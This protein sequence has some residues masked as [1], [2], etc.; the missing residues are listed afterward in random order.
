MLHEA[1]QGR[2]TVSL[3]RGDYETL[4]ATGKLPALLALG[5]PLQCARFLEDLLS[6][7]CEDVDE[8][9]LLLAQPLRDALSPFPVVALEMLVQN[10]GQLHRSAMGAALVNLITQGRSDGERTVILRAISSVARPDVEDD[11]EEEEEAHESVLE[12]DEHASN[13]VVAA[14]SATGVAAV[15]VV[16][17][18]EQCTRCHLFKTRQHFARHQRKTRPKGAR[19]CI[20]CT[21][22]PPGAA[23]C[24]CSNCQVCCVLGFCSYLNCSMLLFF[25]FSSCF[26][27]W[28]GGP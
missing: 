21:R 20:D 22:P 19:Q 8:L 17:I 5:T 15:T 11:G 3:T 28:G 25:C 2:D 12:A 16:D 26:F 6:A 13:A 23:L 14:V 27:F 18:G 4:I 10:C 9:L 24:L 7:L 1:L